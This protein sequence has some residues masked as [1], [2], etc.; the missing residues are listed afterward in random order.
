MNVLKQIQ[1]SIEFL[2]QQIEMCKEALQELIQKDGGLKKIFERLQT[3]PGVGYEMASVWICY[4]QNLIKGSRESAS[5]FCGVAPLN[6]DSGK[7]QGHRSTGHGPTGLKR[8]LYMAALVGTRYNPVLK[9]YYLSLI[10]RHKKPLVALIACSRKVLLWLR[11]M[12][13]DGV[14]WQQMN[15]CKV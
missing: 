11:A 1:T 9:K 7:Y 8:I 6:R 4:G 10:D 3:M 14:T 2:T 5:A 15:I 12:H 13:R